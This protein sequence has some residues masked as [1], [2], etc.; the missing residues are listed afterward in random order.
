MINRL[1]RFYPPWL[2]LSWGIG[3][4]FL[5]WQ[6][7]LAAAWRDGPEFVD[8]AWVLG[9]AHPA[10]YPLYQ[11]L[12]WMWE[13][14]PFADVV[15]RNHSFSVACTVL[16]SVLLYHVSISFMRILDVG[17]LTW[18]ISQF[19]AGFVSLSWLVMPPQLENAIQ[20]EA[21]ALH[22]VFTFAI[23]K[24]LL[25]FM[26]THETRHYVLAIFL[27]GL[28]ASNHITMGALLFAF[29]VVLGV[30]PDMRRAVRTAG[31]GI[32]A[33]LWGLLAYLY[34]PVRSL[35]N[36]AYDWGNPETWG[37][38]WSHV[39]D[40]KDSGGFFV[41]DQG[42][43]IFGAP[44]MDYVMMLYDWLGLLGLVAILVGWGW[45]LWR[46]FR[47]AAVCLPWLI[48]LFLL[49]PGWI[50]GTI[51]TGALG[52]LL[53]GLVPV[54]VAM[55][56]WWRKAKLPAIRLA[57][58]GSVVL[59]LGVMFLNLYQSGIIFLAK[60]ADYLPTEAVE[61]E[62]LS[63]PYRASILA[64]SYVFHLRTL[65]DING[66]RPDVSLIGLG[67]VISP[68]YFKPLQPEQ[69]PLLIYPSVKLP[70]NDAPE[71]ELVKGFIVE[72]LGKNSDRTSFYL[73]LDPGY[74]EN[75]L[76]SIDP[77]EGLL[78]VLLAPGEKRKPGHCRRLAG[79]L[80]NRLGPQL[81]EAKAGYDVENSWFLEGQYFSWLYV[82]LHANPPC[83][84]LAQNM[85]FWWM[86]WMD[87]SHIDME[88]A[89]YNNMGMVFA[90]RGHD[91]GALVMFRLAE[92]LGSMHGSLNLARW[93]ELH[94]QPHQAVKMFKQT[95]L[96]FGDEVAFQNYRR[97]LHQLSRAGSS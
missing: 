20:S 56:S 86:R 1:F 16:A 89:I 55:L 93:H 24:L 52:V 64:S 61:R 48:F 22:A 40:Q 57:S 6:A 29:I 32:L 10:G 19:I 44:A 46:R 75:F 31:A 66:M 92:S 49:I 85:T 74:T 15:L 97:L 4:V 58:L 91:R 8:S 28:G 30:L 70:E 83:P 68:Q 37:R 39:L 95:F 3:T 12:V 78:A 65:A 17:R 59:L 73:E 87:L 71:M 82:A 47:L 38:F 33:G 2:V 81:Q 13:Q 69:I 14:F 25:D 35:R 90:F 18:R 5:I 80:A 77:R 60:R 26:R 9:I 41:T 7:R 53:L 45:L 34:L 62:L 42:E 11:S 72:L 36:P 21:Y 43:S 96:R 84:S 23:F 76:S 94:G 54:L 27:A 67:D 79:I 51:F 50:S 63:L 88:E